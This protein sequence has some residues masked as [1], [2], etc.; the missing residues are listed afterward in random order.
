VQELEVMLIGSKLQNAEDAATII[1]L[2]HEVASLPVPPA[3]LGKRCTSY[4][5]GAARGG[6]N[7]RPLGAQVFEQRR[8][9]SQQP[10]PVPP[11]PVQKRTRLVHPSVL[12]GHVSRLA[13]GAGAGGS[14]REGKAAC[15]V[16]LR[17]KDDGLRRRA[18]P[19]TR[20]RSRARGGR[21][22]LAVLE[23]AVGHG[24]APLAAP[25]GLA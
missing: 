6:A 3:V 11:P 24:A 16:A 7:G 25:F 14:A 10:A 21:A 9:A 23:G 18:A 13:A 8:T 20:A 22:W 17:E 19:G 5:L 1:E 2:R 4:D 15:S 12:T